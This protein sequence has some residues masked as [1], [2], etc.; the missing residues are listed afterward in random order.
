MQKPL[1][2]SLIRTVLHKK[3]INFANFLTPLY[4]PCLEANFHIAGAGGLRTCFFEVEADAL[5]LEDNQCMGL[6]K[7]VGDGCMLL[8]LT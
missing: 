7:A 5:H 3:A 8:S 6:T 2:T 4:H 1:K